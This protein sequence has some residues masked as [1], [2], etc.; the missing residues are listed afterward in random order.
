MGPEH[1][2]QVKGILA[3]ALEQPPDSRDAFLEQACRSERRDLLTEVRRLLVLHER[4]GSALSHPVVDLRE[5]PPRFAAGDLVARRFRIARF[6][7]RGG[8]GDVYE[9][10]DLELGERV[11]L[12]TI[13]PEIASDE[14]I[15]AR[16]K[17]EVQLARRVTHPSV[18]RIYDLAQHADN[19][20]PPA[21][22]LSMELLTGQTLTEYLKEHGPLTR[23]EALPLIADMAAALEA[24]HR[25]GVIHRD[26][27]PGNVML[28]TGSSGGG[29]RAVV[30]DFGLALPP[31]NDPPETGGTPGYMAPEQSGRGEI[32]TASDVYSLGVVIAEMLGAHRRARRS[33]LTGTLRRFTGLGEPPLEGMPRRGT[34]WR[35]VLDRCLASD[36][37]KRFRSPGEV[38]RSLG[39]TPGSRAG[40]RRFIAA[41]GATL[42]AVALTVS[43]LLDT[44][45][46]RTGETVTRKIVAKGNLEGVEYL[47]V[48]PDGSRFAITD[49]ATGDLALFDP[50]TGNRTRLTHGPGG[51]P[52]GAVALSAV[53]ATQ[54]G[55][56]AFAWARRRGSVELRVMGRDGAGIAC[57]IP[58]L[59]G[60]AFDHRIGLPTRSAFSS[61]S[62]GRKVRISPLSRPTRER[63]PFLGTRNCA[64]A[65]MP[66]FR[67]MRGP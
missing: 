7:A 32:T 34:R 13:R 40:R 47:R 1:W 52:A 3:L 65:A 17:K 54:D 43:T 36:P 20:R 2:E 21:L 62:T 46:N 50:A 11:A 66:S 51:H 60:T 25:A 61:H 15:L 14:G 23:K 48:A 44:R 27:K 4:A 28:V 56:L 19:P 16:F 30:T 5:H 39:V 26:F 24:A 22:L 37:A 57:S 53:F 29:V 18:C 8:M 31:G 35:Q 45:A 55:R 64:R 10:D 33:S 42:A 41:T 67:P 63:Y 9:A 59:P 58:V 12:K 49:W 38:A 6:I